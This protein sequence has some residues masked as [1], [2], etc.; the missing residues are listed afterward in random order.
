MK[1]YK[2][3][4]LSSYPLI[5]SYTFR[6]ISD[7]GWLSGGDLMHCKGDIKSIKNEIVPENVKE[8][9]IIY[10]VTEYVDRFFKD[11]HPKIKNKY[12][13]ITGRSDRGIKQS[14]LQYIDDKIIQ[15]F[16]SNVETSH[17][18][19]QSIPLGLQ[20]KHW[21]ILNHPQSDSSLI[22]KVKNEKLNKEQDVLIS[23]QIFTNANE[24][25]KCFNYFKDKD[26]V[27]IRS[28]NNDNRIDRN[29]VK[30][31]FQEIKKSKFVACPFGNGFDCHRNWETFSL[32]SFPII[33]KHKSMEEFYDMP[34]WFVNDWSEVTKENID[35]KY[36]EL[37]QKDF[38][39]D[40]ITFDYWFKKIIDYK[41]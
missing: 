41:K 25:N 24:R 31:Y 17:P 33:K 35:L 19:L 11:I 34:A 30:E 20:N 26:F 29:F 16:S 22:Q 18:K 32:G 28:Y 10:V 4:N 8:N 6:L 7:H 13:L 12:I 3:H 37:K 5:S 14:D 9:D 23:F 15:W 38:N 21:R 2:E 40:K 36:N 39:L 1:N 27:K